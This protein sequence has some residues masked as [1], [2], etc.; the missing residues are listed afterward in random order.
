MYIQKKKLRLLFVAMLFIK[1]HAFNKL[2]T[3]VENDVQQLTFI[4]YPLFNIGRLHYVSGN[5]TWD[6]NRNNKILKSH[7][8]H[9]RDNSAADFDR[10]FTTRFVNG[11]SADG[12]KIEGLILY[13]YTS[14][15]DLAHD[16]GEDR[17]GAAD[18]RAHHRHQRV[19]EHEALRTQ[20]PARVTVQH[21]DH[22]WHVRA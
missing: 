16:V 17:A 3:D 7:T 10:C 4:K 12:F 11:T 6:C 2:I 1:C 8:D 20:R 21:G 5:S 9:Q 22:H 19:V 13:S 14:I 15:I 18:E